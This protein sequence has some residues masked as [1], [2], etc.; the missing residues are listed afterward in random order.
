MCT[1]SHLFHFL[2]RGT[3]MHQL[4]FWY[5]SSFTI[6]LDGNGP[7]LFIY[8]S[9]TNHLKGVSC[10]IIIHALSSSI[11]ISELHF[12]I[13]ISLLFHSPTS[14]DLESKGELSRCKAYDANY[15]SL[16]SCHEFIIQR[17]AAPAK[18]FAR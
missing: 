1:N 13:M 9:K 5:I 3:K 8:Q 12:I 2:C 17:L 15:H 16:L 4:L 6:F 7:T 14:T 10:Q 11:Y 18:T